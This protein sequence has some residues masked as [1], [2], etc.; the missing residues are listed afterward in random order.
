M[1][2]AGHNGKIRTSK[3]VGRKTVGRRASPKIRR[4]VQI[5]SAVWAPPAAGW[6]AN[7]R[8]K[9]LRLLRTKYSGPDEYLMGRLS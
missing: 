2:D 9:I 4:D 8:Q 1:E 6:R 3:S 5:L 7:R